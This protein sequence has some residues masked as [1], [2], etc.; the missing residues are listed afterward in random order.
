MQPRSRT[1]ARTLS[2][3]SGSVNYVHYSAPDTSWHWTWNCDESVTLTGGQ[4]LYVEGSPIVSG[5]VS[6]G[7]L[8]GDE[9]IRYN[10][11][12]GGYWWGSAYGTFA[13]PGYTPASFEGSSPTNLISCP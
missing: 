6:D 11:C 7:G 4:A 1:R 10:G 3:T 13:A 8:Y 5:P 12:V 2:A 9:N